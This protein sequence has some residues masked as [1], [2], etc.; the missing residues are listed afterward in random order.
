MIYAN[1][2]MGLSFRQFP[3]RKRWVRVVALACA[4]CFLMPA[5][6][7]AFSAES[8]LLPPTQ[9]VRLDG[10][11]SER[12]AAEYQ[13]PPHLGRVAEASGPGPFT[14]ILI[15]DLHC[16]TGI[17]ANIRGMLDMLC[18]RYPELRLV[19]VEGGSGIIP[20]LELSA[21]PDT[22][23]KRAVTEYFVRTGKLTGA[24]WLA[25]LD[26]PELELFGA[27]DADLYERSLV[28]IRQF[29]NEENRGLMQ[30]LL[31][32][33]DFLQEQQFNAPLLSFE[34]RRK[35]HQRGDADP[36]IYRQDLMREAQR[37][38]LSA[39]PEELRGW[40]R[41][42]ELDYYSRNLQVQYLE[43]QLRNRLV[44][45]PAEQQLLRY[46]EWVELT[47]RILNISASREDLA[48]HRVLGQEVTVAGL[49]ELIQDNPTLARDLESLSVSLQQ[50]SK[51]YDLAAQ[52]DAALFRNTWERLKDRGEQRAVLI[53]GGYH[54]E[55]IRDLARQAGQAF[56]VIRPAM[57][58][59]ESAARYFELLR[60]PD[61]P[62]EFEQLLARQPAGPAAMAVR[63]F[64]TLP[65]FRQ[66]F[67]RAIVF[68]EDSLRKLGNSSYLRLPG[69]TMERPRDRLVTLTAEDQSAT[70]GLQFTRQGMQ[71]MSGQEVDAYVAR[72]TALRSTQLRISALW[73]LSGGILAAVILPLLGIVTTIPT[74][75]VVAGSL[76]L[77]AA[78]WIS[79]N[80]TGD[81]SQRLFTKRN[82]I[83]G[84][85]VLAAV[86]IPIVAMPLLSDIVVNLASRAPGLSL[87][88]QGLTAAVDR[89]LA[90]VPLTPQV[91]NPAQALAIAQN[92]QMYFGS[93]MMGGIF[94]ITQLANGLLGRR[95]V[96]QEKTTQAQLGTD[97]ASLRAQESTRAITQRIKQ[98]FGEL[99]EG[100]E[101]RPWPGAF[102]IVSEDIV[103]AWLHLLESN[104]LTRFSDQLLVDWFTKAE[105]V[106]DDPKQIYVQPAPIASEPLFRLPRN[107][108]EMAS[109]LFRI[110][111]MDPQFLDDKDRPLYKEMPPRYIEAVLNSLNPAA[112]YQIL[113][114]Q[115]PEQ[116][117][118]AGE[119]AP[120]FE[121]LL[122]Y[123]AQQWQ[124]KTA[125]RDYQTLR[126]FISLAFLHEAVHALLLHMP[127]EI[128]ADLPKA[129]QD[130]LRSISLENYLRLINGDPKLQTSVVFIKNIYK[131]LQKVS[132]KPAGAETRDSINILIA[133]ETFCDRFSMY[134][135][136][137]YLKIQI[138]NQLLKPRLGF[139]INIDQ[140]IVLETARSKG[141]LAS[142]ALMQGVTPQELAKLATDLNA[143][144]SD[145]VY[146]S[147]YGD[148]KITT[149]EYK[150]FNAYLDLLKQFDSENKIMRFTMQHAN[151]SRFMM[152]TAAGLVQEVSIGVVDFMRQ[153]AWLWSG[154]AALAKSLIDRV[155][156]PRQLRTD[157][158]TEGV[159]RE[160]PAPVAE[161]TAAEQPPMI[162]LTAGKSTTS[163]ASIQAQTMPVVD[164]AAVGAE[165]TQAAP[166]RSIRSLLEQEIDQPV[167]QLSMGTATATAPAEGETV[168]SLEVGV[169]Q[170]VGTREAK[171][172]EKPKTRRVAGQT[173]TTGN[174]DNVLLENNQDLATVARN[175][176]KGSEDAAF[177][178]VVTAAVIDTP[179]QARDF[180]SGVL[181]SEAAALADTDLT[182]LRDTPADGIPVPGGV[183][184]QPGQG[185]PLQQFTVP[186]VPGV[187]P[188][189]NPAG[190][191]GTQGLLQPG[192]LIPGEGL[193]PGLSGVESARIILGIQESG[194]L[195]L[196][197]GPGLPFGSPDSRS[198]LPGGMKIPAPGMFPS[199]VAALAVP[200]AVRETLLADPRILYLLGQAGQILN[201]LPAGQAVTLGLDS[202]ELKA[203]LDGF[204][205]ALR[206]S[207]AGA[208]LAN[209]IQT[210]LFPQDPATGQRLA[211]TNWRAANGLVVLS[212]SGTNLTPL[213]VV[214]GRNGETTVGV[215][216]SAIKMDE[217][218]KAF[219]GQ[220]GWETLQADHQRLLAQMRN[221]ADLEG[222]LLVSAATVQQLQRTPG[223]V[224]NLLTSVVG[225]QTAAQTGIQLPLT[226]L[227]TAAQPALE[228]GADRVV[229]DFNYTAY[230]ALERASRTNA[231][232][233]ILFGLSEVALAS[234]AGYDFNARFLQNLFGTGGLETTA[235]EAMVE[236]DD[237][238]EELDLEA[239]ALADY[240][241]SVKQF[242]QEQLGEEAARKMTDRLLVN[243]A[244]ALLGLDTATLI[245]RD[246]ALAGRLERLRGQEWV[247]PPS[248]FASDVYYRF[249][250]GRMVTQPRMDV[251]AWSPEVKVTAHERQRGVAKVVSALLLGFAAG[252]LVIDTLAQVAQTRDRQGRRLPLAR[253]L[254]H[255]D[256]LQSLQLMV[257]VVLGQR[258]AVEALPPLV[259]QQV[260][261]L[262][263]LM[264]KQL[265]L[266]ALQ[267]SEIP[268]SLKFNLN[269]F[270][271]FR[272]FLANHPVFRLLMRL[273]NIQNLLPLYPELFILLTESN[274]LQSVMWYFA[275]AT[276]LQRHFNQLEGAQPDLKANLT[277]T[278]DQAR[279]EL[280]RLRAEKQ[281]LLQA[282][283]PSAERLAQ[284]ETAIK[285][286]RFSLL[287]Q[288]A[289]DRLERD[290]SPQNLRRVVT[291]LTRELGRRDV[292]TFEAYQESL[293]QILTR[294]EPFQQT[295]VQIRLDSG[296]VIQTS[297]PASVY[298]TPLRDTMLFFLDVFST[299]GKPL[300]PVRRKI[301]RTGAAA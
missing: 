300:P 110:V 8:Y 155:T 220:P 91:H 9:G 55:A 272:Q 282:P 250:R 144:E 237:L 37:A 296:K 203:R 77:L 164:I 188:A 10:P 271:R 159:V 200:G 153:N 92:T 24:D 193:Q 88:L 261:D 253:I 29:A 85:L 260:Q 266:E 156:Q 139:P 290:G 228:Q 267:P 86:V 135:Y 1:K 111:L 212:E 243:Q 259:K 107:Q 185:T 70:M 192:Q 68:I 270:M 199:L 297:L 14:F 89:V 268:A 197:R 131:A 80:T 184:A 166:R 289:L 163:L 225:F 196:L 23:A 126:N 161:V 142:Q 5:I 269:Q 40:E 113:R 190:V 195:N 96:R 264:D 187:N 284:V 72:P 15:Q 180:A 120:S 201:T 279:T 249:K 295:A 157:L 121:Q 158:D 13:I 231:Q 183:F 134:L 211:P 140:M 256:F 69:L 51:F 136:E 204:L 43:T 274:Q 178:A 81:F 226:A 293:L 301:L 30:E 283:A 123:A 168:A 277:R 213:T 145:H 275:P 209:R 105:Q 257:R 73:L 189:A 49:Q 39:Y 32:Q 18:A 128:P 102:A 176:E 291:L 76:M 215:R 99:I 235:V 47:E 160:A 21:L 45:T 7:F 16:H 194:R 198:L 115:L 173:Q 74:L 202:P 292:A 143:A 64:L 224:N 124:K 63:N 150:F 116:L 152:A 112:M 242:V 219:A 59:M 206:V 288:R 97:F 93:T 4:L 154:P 276:T 71:V 230:Q 165:E 280:A 82:I 41:N 138:Y 12:L 298:E 11:G 66:Q 246:Q 148:P 42:A 109:V 172:P 205:Q 3:Q 162:E 2:I 125:P 38:K 251:D 133:L 117:T 241:N 87:H 60:A 20:T 127:D 233:M 218:R 58:H 177:G 286:Q 130:H 299:E 46:Q 255:P 28:L 141:T 79:T 221:Q 244:E 53:T 137:N 273:V 19:A 181:A 114:Q 25:I 167:I 186:R 54:T 170:Q 227:R 252:T 223:Q 254:T 258:R 35:F 175:T 33:L 281:Q 100:E 95:E 240:A 48:R 62:T 147:A 83:L 78:W 239:E 129:E 61:Q 52:R 214:M 247:E 84:I 36:E 208:E 263:G 65:V 174:L 104:G 216:V 31:D 118:R 265:A 238:Q 94:G 26:R 236:R 149:E 262:Q 57:D 22:A 75:L 182:G 222:Y 122:K 234:V 294:I 6:G 287:L 103:A 217:A 146:I 248:L 27:E 17:Q 232:G 207:A 191:L 90:V 151:S 171:R 119:N 285:H 278:A 229:V 245:I 56:V 210:E 44:R 34:R 179:S 98:K 108:N 101:Q 169:Q 50:A 106:N 67:Q 132:D